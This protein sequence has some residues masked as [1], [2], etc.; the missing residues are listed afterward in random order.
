MSNL[1]RP[2]NSVSA[3][4]L[5]EF[6]SRVRASQPFLSLRAHLARNVFPLRITGSKG[7][8]LP[9]LLG[10]IHALGRSTS[11]IVTPTER[12]A[13]SLGQDLA[14]FARAET[15][16][17]P[18][19]ETVPYE[20]ASPLATLFGDRA[21]ALIR[22]LR[23]EHMLLVAPLRSLLTPLPDPAELKGQTIGVSKGDKL[24][25][26][27]FAE[28][29]TRLGYLRVPTVS[30]HGEFAI[31]GEVADVFLPG[32]AEAVRIQ[33][34]FDEVS[35]IKRFDPTNQYTIGT[36]KDVDIHP[37]RE[38]IF[39]EEDLSR[40]R[41]ALL[42]QEYDEE[43]VD[44]VLQRI[45]EDPLG[46][47]VEIFYPLCSES[48]HSLFDYL[49]ADAT[50]FLVDPERLSAG[51]A[52]LRKEYLE[53]FRRARSKGQVVPGPQRI[54][55]DYEELEPRSVR[56]ISIH[57]TQQPEAG[58]PTFHFPCDAPRSFF[59]NFTFFKEEVD[60][61][62]K[63]GYKLYVFA[64]YDVQ[65]ERLAHILK[66]T[67]AVILPQG[68]SAGFSL[69][70]E[71]I[72]VIQ[73]GEIFGRKRR[74]P[75][76]VGSARSAAIDSF[77]ELAPGDFVVHVNY[78]IGI[79]LGIERIRAAGNERDY[80]Q[81][82]Y[83]GDEKLYIPIEQV[84]LV[85]RY[86]GQEG[87]R[88]RLDSIGSKAWE[89]R[90]E[91]VRKSVEE[92]AQQLLELYSKR[93]A[94]QGYAFPRDTDWQSEFEAAFPFQET[95]DQLKCIDEVKADMEKPTAMDR[96][97]CGDV[98]YGK[99]EVALRA[100]FK[101]VMGGK[102]VALLA[103]TTILVEQH[104]E[105]FKERFQNYPVRIEMLS[106]FRPPKE[107][108]QAVVKAA[109]GKVDLVIGT[110]RLV[111]KDVKFRNLGLLIVDEEQRFGVKHK[112]RLKQL[113]TNVDCL[114]LTATPIPR[115]LNMS[116][117][118]L[119]DMSVLNTA[120]QNRI[121]IET[122]VTEFNEELVAR[123]IRTEVERGGQ[124]YYLH[125]RVE[126]IQEILVFLQGLVPEV[127]V[128]VAHGQ[129]EEEELEEVM[130]QFI[131]RERQ[132][133]LSTTIIENGLDIP[134]VNTIII[135][136]ADMMGLSQLYQLRGR[137]GRAGIPAYAYLLYPDRRALSEIAM[138]R[139]RI[140][141]EHTELGSGFKIALKDLEIRG[142]GNILGREQ[143]GYMLSV[144]FDMYLRLLDQAVAELERKDRDE[145]PEVYLELEYS[146][147]IP[148][149]YISEPVEKM[150]VYKKVAGVVTDDELDRLHRELEDRF[151]PL[152]EEVQSV[153]SLAEIRV[154]CRKLFVTSLREKDGA[155]SIEFSRLSRVSVDKVVRMI[156]ESGGRAFLDPEHPN[157][158]KLKAG[159]IGLREKSEFIRGRL[160]MLV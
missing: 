107:I 154:I 96:M 76:S 85:Q 133:L 12:E 142:A 94:E 152:P 135:D 136:R 131:H 97:I 111:Q 31:R 51:A 23:G 101:A 151:G 90:K 81:L 119:R 21:H 2:V 48:P 79:F 137:V 73:E 108:K 38:V 43:E 158:L 66:D 100:A 91:K 134:N 57:E 28:T 30:V 16:S 17:F 124:V 75:K 122:F 69:P 65:A 153:L 113:K 14:A 138:K 45:A 61:L 145:P 104:Y 60:A 115:T 68:I 20:G 148:D 59:G 40:L 25:P 37:T 6:S 7:G 47:G 19:W 41:H 117:M 139:L 99:T 29:L 64:I 54:L 13:E 35:E 116:L 125:N 121:P 49:G 86:I 4:F 93:K 159:G 24:D 77:V 98:G 105:T 8:F 36:A 120:P 71:K 150:E 5:Q 87:R 103:P 149:T 26:L 82:Q 11:L 83:D 126:T 22:L 56:R 10:E 80:I 89:K 102:Q 3:P 157:F 144:G 123:A 27:R 39:T 46:N 58:P 44:G 34:D 114:T 92:L 129:M 33:L 95:E 70:Q 50:V 15:V 53:L 9:L 67:E 109:E 147:F 156:K 78:G 42:A 128:I 106:R 140:L 74:V 52:G 155:I 55:L 146:G 88:P 127:S 18:W 1:S 143:H 62:L 112:E 110:H 141:S 84:N 160:A 63:S 32:E 130:H 132:V 72:A 118:K